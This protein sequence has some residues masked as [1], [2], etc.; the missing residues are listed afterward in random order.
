METAVHV[1]VLCSLL[2]VAMSSTLRAGPKGRAGHHWFNTC[3]KPGCGFRW[4]LHD[5]QRARA[6]LKKHAWARG[7]RDEILA[8]CKQLYDL[9]PERLAALVPDKTP[10]VSGRCPKC[11]A[12]FAL[13][14][15]DDHGDVLRC[16]R[17]QSTWRW[18]PAD[19]SEKWD[20]CGA[21]RSVRIRYLYLFVDHIGLAYLL[22]GE[23]VHAERVKAIVTRFARV[24][25]GYKMSAIHKNVFLKGNHVYYGKIDGWKYRDGLCVSQMLLAYDYVRDSDVFTDDERKFIDEHLVRYAMDYFIESFG[26]RG[27]V[28]DNP[29]QDLGYSLKTI[30]LAAAILDDQKVLH[31]MATL[32]RDL[33]SGKKSVVFFPEDGAFYQGTYHYAMQL[34]DA[35]VFIT[36][37]LADNPE[38]D[39]YRDPQCALLRKAL[40]YPYP[41][42][43]PNGIPA[44][45]NDSHVA[46]S[47][48]ESD[49]S[50]ELSQ[51]AYYRYGDL[52]S[53]MRIKDKFGADL[54]KGNVYALFRRPPEGLDLSQAQPY[55]EQSARL[56]GLRLGVLR[57]GKPRARQTMAFLDYGAFPRGH[58][59]PDFLNINLWAKGMLMVT[60]MGYCTGPNWLKAWQKSSMAHNVVLELAA[61]KARKSRNT[62]W[63]ITP[64]VKAVEGG[65]PGSEGRRLL[66]LVPLGGLEC[67]FID[68]LWA[69]A[70][71]KSHTWVLHAASDKIK[72]T[73]ITKPAPVKPPYVLRKGRRTTVANDVSVTWA[74]SEERFL[75]TTLLGGQP[76]EITLAECPPEEN[77]VFNAHTKGGARIKGVPFPYRAII[78]ARRTNEVDCFAAVH[79]P[80]RGERLLRRIER[81][82]V[83]RGEGIALQATFERGGATYR[84]VLVQA[85]PGSA[86]SVVA[87]GVKLTGRAALVRLRRT[88]DGEEPVFAVLM[89]GRTLQRG[90]IDLRHPTPANACWTPAGHN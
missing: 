17:C 57:H 72:T 70:G 43:Y 19:K 11:G 54:A 26:K 73:G 22:T 21:H 65:L 41:M 55:N 87:A 6:N 69:S 9:P 39:V 75:R 24:Y 13:G 80:Y 64:H 45:I 2:L 51:I 56:D 18:D 1:I 49:W 42:T 48:W 40:T 85:A 63:C 36:E 66:A 37:L 5:V 46:G 31:S 33:C 83:E 44:P 15:P 89:N 23:R 90:P 58:G 28:A 52:R 10:L 88:A 7:V 12:H 68:V 79:E 47:Y 67:Y 34:L 3:G 86:A 71:K 29:N 74:F 84:D 25:P 62:V 53:L 77:L 8:R 38:T 76:T 27:F 30:A 50:I 78:L 16:T 60:E 32:F 4:L 82:P 81:L 14:V 20:V 59:Q 35:A 61:H